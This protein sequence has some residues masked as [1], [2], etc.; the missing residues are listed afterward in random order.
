MINKS[1][2]N[3]DFKEL[4]LHSKN[5][6]SAEFISL[7]IGF[8]ALPFYT[9]LLS[10]SD[11]G[12][13]SVFI[14][15][16]TLLSVILGLGIRGAILRYFY[17]DKGDFYDFFNTNITLSFIIGFILILGFFFFGKTIQSFF[18]I[19][20][21]L[22]YYGVIIS[23]FTVFI[24]LYQAYLQASKKSVVLSF[25][26]IIQ[27]VIGVGFS[28]LIMYYLAEEKY[29]G[30]AYAM[31]ASVLVLTIIIFYR[32]RF[33]FSFSLKKKYI[34]Y[35]LSFGLP[36][37]LHLISQ[38][39]LTTFDQVMINNIL[40]EKETGLYS[41]AYRIGMIQNSIVAATLVAWT[42]I[43]YK[44]INLKKYLDN[45]SLTK[46]YI[47]IITFITLSLIL[48]SKEILTI[49]ADESYHEALPVIP[50][51]VIGYF[52]FF[53][54]SIYVVHSFYMKKTK[55]IT[56]TTILVGTINVSLNFLLIPIYGY[57]GA[58][59]STLISYLILF[60]IHFI[61]SKYRYKKY[62]PI[63][64]IFLI[65]P[66]VLII[67]GYFFNSYL[68]IKDFDFLINIFL[69]I[70]GM[71]FFTSILFFLNKRIN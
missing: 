39:I 11:F 42:P 63:N 55:F 38:N 50:I 25:Q 10:P 26:K 7:L 48:F 6:L 68:I 19:P 8:I 60:L 56:F 69:K 9:R 64:F 32:I 35:S 70:L 57:I 46:K 24:Q 18:E 47:I 14:S 67:I 66:S 15:F 51:V 23:F 4:I 34:V 37:V 45:N 49:F 2:F 59:W 1:I 65:I 28:V 16:V 53:L 13:M 41:I 71:M 36:I 12:I 33:F 40:G 58:A 27:V 52:L 20:L 30:R 21:T 3:K 54:Y 31:L 17:E 44:N 61:I 5:Y 29:Y 62:I 43:F 22:L